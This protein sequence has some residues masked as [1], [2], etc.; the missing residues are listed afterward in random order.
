MSLDTA[1]RSFFGLVGIAFLAYIGAGLSACVVAALFLFRVAS[2]GLEVVA[3]EGYALV[4]ALLFLALV[5]LG[6]VLGVLSL[7]V[8]ARSSRRLAGR[9][10]ALRLP[11]PAALEAAAAR[12]GLGRRVRLIDSREPF[13]FAYGALSPRV[14][15]SRGIL[16]G[17]SERELEAVLEHEAYHVRSLDPL[18]VVVARA[19]TAALYFLPALGGLRARY[20][21][22][23]ELAAD[24]RA[25][26][27]RGREPLV[28]ALLKVVG[29][30]AWADLGTAAAIGGPELIDA[31]VAQLEEGREPAVAGPSGGAVALSALAGGL[32]AAAVVIAVAG[33]GGLTAVLE[34]TMPEM[35]IGATAIATGVAACALPVMAGGLALYRWLGW[36]AARPR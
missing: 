23:R 7:V 24:R 13:S 8:Q 3:D 36:R 14:A 15:V 26:E 31:R 32:I 18:K 6:A 22:A 27:S 12:A 9:L 11:S 35:E 19:L 20:V 28:A 16:D 4:P 2:E 21:A 5:G 30:P 25:V 17:L 33:S 29:G 10:E 1:N 34:M